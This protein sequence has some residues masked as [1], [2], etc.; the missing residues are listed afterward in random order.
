MVNKIKL[1]INF[2]TLNKNRKI[3]N[4]NKLD[5]LNNWVSNY[6]NRLNQMF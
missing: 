5:H 4:F 6:P 1:M 2:P 3:I